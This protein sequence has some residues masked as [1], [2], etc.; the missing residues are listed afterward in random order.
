MCHFPILQRART[1]AGRRIK[2]VVFAVRILG[3]G[4][5]AKE[6]LDLSEKT[7]SFRLRRTGR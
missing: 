5:G 3:V 7:R 4:A 2:S 6:V 1:Q